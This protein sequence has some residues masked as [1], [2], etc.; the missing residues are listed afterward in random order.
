MKC[1]LNWKRP[2]VFEQELLI[3]MT[4]LFAAHENLMTFV[5]EREEPGL[6]N[7][8]DILIEQAKGMSSG[9]YV[10]VR[11]ALDIWNDSGGVQISELINR[12]D[13]T[14]FENAMAALR[15]VGPKRGARVTSLVPDPAWDGILF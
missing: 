14:N 1:P 5:F 15:Y 10:L 4:K 7:H 6:R 11:L 13:A 9:E 3:A 12:L 2:R 8:P